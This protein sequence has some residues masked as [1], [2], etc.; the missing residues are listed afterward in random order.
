MFSASL[1]RKPAWAGL[2]PALPEPVDLPPALADEILRAVGLVGRLTGLRLADDAV[3]HYRLE[4]PSGPPIFVKLVGAPQREVAER[5]EAIARWLAGRGLAVSSLLD[6]FPRRIRDGRLAVAAR[7][8]EGRR[9]STDEADL[10]VLGETIGNLH[11]VLAGHP[12]RDEWARATRVRL[13]ALTQVRTGLADGLLRCG[14][15]PDRLCILAADPAAEFDLGCA[16]ATALHGDLNPGTV[17]VETASGRTVVLDFEDVLHSVLP[18][19]FELLLAAERFVLVMVNDDEKA[20]VLGRA[21][22]ASYR[23]SA[24]TRLSLHGRA[25]A[26]LLR[27][28]ALRSMCVL[29]F[30]ERAGIRTVD[31][32]W[33]KFLVLEQQARQRAPLI[34]R[35]IGDDA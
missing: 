19:I 27:G 24:A 25:P 5:A 8:I 1:I 28:L 11:R 32:E 34:A 12:D 22:V 13:D 29:A 7:F 33:R 35:I 21:L 18:P 17:L 10:A 26:A 30:G 3:E 6:G 31:E 20:L 9:V 4:P 15:E 2:V 23:R 16:N 14:P